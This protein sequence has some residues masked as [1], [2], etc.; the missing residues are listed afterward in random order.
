MCAVEMQSLLLLGRAHHAP[1]IS[2]PRT[3]S[4][5]I[6]QSTLARLHHLCRLR[7]PVRIIAD[8]CC[9]LRLCLMPQSSFQLRNCRCTVDISVGNRSCNRIDRV[10]ICTSHSPFSTSATRSSSLARVCVRMQLRDGL[11]LNPQ[12][13]NSS[14]MAGEQMDDMSVIHKTASSCPYRTLVQPVDHTDEGMFERMSDVRA[15]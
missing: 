13:K 7:M 14:P 8:W 9:S 11:L 2:K 4:L 3:P 12:S 1:P 10:F 6:V 15:V 5:L